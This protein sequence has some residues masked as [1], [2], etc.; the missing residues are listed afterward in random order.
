M[1]IGEFTH[2][3]ENN[4]VQLTFSTKPSFQTQMRQKLRESGDWMVP[5]FKLGREKK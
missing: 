3:E 5:N 1:Q 4:G 2:K